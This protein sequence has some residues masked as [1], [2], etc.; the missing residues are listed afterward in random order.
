[1][2][3]LRVLIRVPKARAPLCQVRNCERGK[4]GKKRVAYIWLESKRAFMRK[5]GR[6]GMGEGVCRRGRGGVNENKV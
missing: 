2:E 1:M 5:D 4:V 3:G 6:R